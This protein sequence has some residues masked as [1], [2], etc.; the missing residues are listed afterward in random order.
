MPEH[1][2]KLEAD[3]AKVEQD[4]AD[5][6]IELTKKRAAEIKKIEDAGG[7]VELK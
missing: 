3:K 1:K 6:S 4:A 5:A 2:E 7:K